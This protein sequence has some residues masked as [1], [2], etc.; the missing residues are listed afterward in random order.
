MKARRP[1]VFVSALV[2]AAGMATRMGRQKV[3]L[4]LAGVPLVRH[5]VDAALA[6]V[7]RETIVVVG[8]EAAAVTD[9]VAGRGV[10]VVVNDRFAEGMSG[11]LRAGLAA[12]DPS[13]AAVLV[14]LADQPFVTSEV[15]DRLVERF[16]ATRS[17]IVRPAVDGRPANPVLLSATLFP[18]IC[19]QRGDFGGREVV[20][21]HHHDVCLVPI[22]DPRLVTD[23]DS[24]EEYAA[25]GERA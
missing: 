18:E 23:I 6:S 25:V 9:A 13:C 11:S 15:I 20:E 5:V 2:L 19:A 17:A 3:L 21:R 14:L 1:E 12:A 22:D 10:I 8:H 4:P 16:A 24:P 7:A